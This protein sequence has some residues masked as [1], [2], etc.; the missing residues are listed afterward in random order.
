MP[1][2]LLL[3]RLAH[4]LP[5]LL[6]AL[7]FLHRE[8]IVH[9][10]LKPSN[11][12]VRRDGV[13]KLLDFGIAGAIG[14][15]A[16]GGTRRSIAGTAGY[17]APEQIRG[18]GPEPATDLYA[19]G[20]M[21]F[22]L[23]AGRR[24]FEG[25]V[26]EVLRQHLEATAPL[27]S[28]YVPGAPAPLVEACSALLRKQPAARADLAALNHLLLRPLGARTVTPPPPRPRHP[29]LRGRAALEL[30]LARELERVQGGEFSALVLLGPS[31][32]GKSALLA[33]GAERAERAGAAVLRGYG[34][35]GERVAFSAV[36]GAIDALAIELSRHR[37]RRRPPQLDEALAL[38]ATAF[39]VLAHAEPRCAPPAANVPRW[40]IFEAVVALLR[41]LAARQRGVLLVLDDLQWAD[42]DAVALLDHLVGVAPA[43]AGVLAALREDSGPCPAAA[44]LERGPAVTRRAVPP[45]GES[46]IA[47]I[48][49]AAAVAAGGAP[50][51]APVLARVV[52]ACAGRPFL[53]EVA[54]RRLAR[55][56]AAALADLP[57]RAGEPSA[58][59]APERWLAESVATS[60]PLARQLL[61]LL[62]AA[63]E[64]VELGRAARL[65]GAGLGALEGEVAALE[66]EGLVRTAGT[67]GPGL[68]VQ[69]YHDAVRAAALEVLGEQALRAAHEVLARDLLVRPQAAPP[70]VLVRHL[71]GAGRIEQA[72]HHA[73]GAAARAEAQRAYALAAEM[74]EVALR[75]PPDRAA[76]RALLRA[77]AEALE[78]AARY[79]EA[80]RCWAELARAARTEPE[81]VAAS[82]G[83]AHALLAAG[84]LAEGHAR[85]QAALERAGEPPA[86]RGR[87]GGLLAGLLFLLGP[88]VQA[89]VLRL[90]GRRRAG[91]PAAGGAPEA[92]RRL[93]ERD[94]RLGTMI[95]YFD[96]LAGVRFLLR[97][98][99]R[100]EAAAA[101][102]QA[103]W[104][105]FVLAYLALHQRGGAAGER[106]A[107]RYT[108][109]AHRRLAQRTV[110]SLVVAWMPA[111]LEGLA[112]LRKGSW[113]QAAAAFEEVARA[114]EQAGLSGGF[115][116]L[117]ALLHRAHVALYAQRPAE[118]AAALERLGR[119]ART[120]GE[121][122][123]R[124]HLAFLE[125]V[126]LT[127]R[128]S[129]AA[130]EARL[131][132]AA[133]ELPEHPPAIQRAVLELYA[134]VPAI[135]SAEP[136]AARQRARQA[137]ARARPF[138][139]LRSM[140]AGP[141]L[142]C[143]AMLEAN[144]LRAGDPEASARRVW[145]L[146]GAAEAAAP[147][148]AGLGLRACAYAADASGER[149]RALALLEQAEAAAGRAGRPLD[150]AIARYQRGRRL[151]GRMGAALIAQA[152]QRLAIAGAS[153]RLLEEDAGLRA[154]AAAG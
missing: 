69:L 108:A 147:L 135:W 137:L 29:E 110:R 148:A 151:G 7:A 93:A 127:W 5:Q 86:G 74:Y 50:P 132:A 89:V 53:A 85:L 63:A 133:A 145:R 114:L 124:C 116:H 36:D 59:L 100:F 68:A 77:R 153:E 123:I 9:R 131:A 142:G 154:T 87:L 81:A 12:L 152:R 126:Q 79:R 105:E 70:H 23:V 44:W 54:G 24:P 34:R 106:L 3:E 13:V 4:V 27:L 6:D 130:A 149:A 104:C 35:P 37:D 21:L 18:E 33:W 26:A 16:H 55:G 2:P 109:S 136:A 49:R 28:E 51:P 71:V 38:A 91:L 19:L 52:P 41:E 15:P 47:A 78:K 72:A 43:G 113:Q 1:A 129:F 61:A 134:L 99:T 107:R 31:G 103:A 45:L 115:E 39:P 150:A 146:G 144:A 119:A 20:V 139:L 25:S 140:F 65:L 32:A 84:A 66:R 122:A 73:P 143:A 95:G 118:L 17:M 102:E 121:S 88:R 75:S 48:V 64:W 30:E 83:E 128:G 96:P 60:P 82:L 8:G 125:A 117:L 76:R 90:A 14:E 98:R 42:D 62:V 10:D 40:R 58:P 11:V 22:E 111:L 141:A 138:G 112:R 67:A 94:V 97:A 80:A 46:D 56:R 92:V 57:E 101:H 120:S